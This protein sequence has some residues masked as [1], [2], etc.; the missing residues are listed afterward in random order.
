MP[1]VVGLHSICLSR[2]LL[3]EYGAHLGRIATSLFHVIAEDLSLDQLLQV[4]SG[5]HLS[6]ATG[7]VRVY[8]YP[9][10]SRAS[11]NWGMDVHTDS[12]VLTILCQD[13]VG[14][15]EV[16]R[17]GDW[18]PVKPVPSTLVVNLG[19]MMQVC[20]L[21]TINPLKCLQTY[22]NFTNNYNGNCD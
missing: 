7:F 19:D 12:S 17:E 21:L 10:C 4:Q 1:P 18:I 6:E 9:Y 14:G 13:H 3:Q 2:S 11:S 16:S 22:S 20:A 5:N 15:L 8:R